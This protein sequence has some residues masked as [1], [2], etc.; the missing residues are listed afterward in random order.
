LKEIN[1]NQKTVKLIMFYW[2]II[3][4][5]VDIQRSNLS[6]LFI[7]LLHELCHTVIIPSSIKEIDDFG[8]EEENKEEVSSGFRLKVG[9]VTN[10]DN[11]VS[12]TENEINVFAIECNYDSFQEYSTYSNQKLNPVA[13]SILSGL[14]S[15]MFGTY[16]QRDKRVTRNSD[17]KRGN[18]EKSLERY[19]QQLHGTHHITWSNRLPFDQIIWIAKCI[20][21]A[22]KKQYDDKLSQLQQKKNQQKS[23]VD[24][25][26]DDRERENKDM[27]RNKYW[28]LFKQLCEKKEKNITTPRTLGKTSWIWWMCMLRKYCQ[29]QHRYKNMNNNWEILTIKYCK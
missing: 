28:L 26:A 10:K 27:I 7:R 19:L 3:D 6:C 4:A 16:Y 17:N 29:L 14:S 2:P 21:P 9:F 20:A 13:S 15:F 8:V 18:D 11:D 5:F 1:K 22:I 24:K 12:F 23:E 25:K